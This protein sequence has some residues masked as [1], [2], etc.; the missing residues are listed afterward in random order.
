[1]SPK[2]FIAPAAMAMTLAACAAQT[3]PESAPP[4]AAEAEPTCGADQFASYVGQQA[5]DATIAAI[6][7]KRG[8][9]PIRVIKPGMA[10][11]MDYRAERLNVDVDESGAIKRFYCS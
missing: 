10:V 7:S 11:T 1:M 9:K 4:P 5:T 2:A 3:P 8:D 6:Q